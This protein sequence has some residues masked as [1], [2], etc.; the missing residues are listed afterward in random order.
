MNFQAVIAAG[1]GSGGCPHAMG[2]CKQFRG[3]AGL[4][5]AGSNRSLLTLSRCGGRAGEE[6]ASSGNQRQAIACLH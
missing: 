4:Q 3:A 5:V 6:V 1:H 2:V